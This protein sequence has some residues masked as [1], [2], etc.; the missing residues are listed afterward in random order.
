MKLLDIPYNLC[1]QVVCEFHP[2]TWDEF[3]RTVV[4]LV[5]E[6]VPL[7]VR[8]EKWN[9]HRVFIRGKHPYAEGKMLNVSLQSRFGH[10]DAVEGVGV[11]YTVYM[12]D[13]IRT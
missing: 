1:R 8:D 2:E 10:V 4:W 3:D 9:E 12:P 6:G 7:S 5:K 13:Y 11:E